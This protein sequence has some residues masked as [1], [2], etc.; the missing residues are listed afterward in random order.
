[1]TQAQGSTN[2]GFHHED[3]DLPSP[4]LPTTI[5][6]VAAAVGALASDTRSQYLVIGERLQALHDRA[7][8]HEKASIRRFESLLAAVVNNTD[9]TLALRSEVTAM[10]THVQHLAAKAEVAELGAQVGRQALE[11]VTTEARQDKA[12]AQTKRLAMVRKGAF[13][14]GI[15]LGTALV[16]EWRAALKLFVSLLGG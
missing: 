14:A 11:S 3:R 4:P 6:D 1:M 16:L 2:G 7:G 9:A 10:G 12:I 13:A 5:D 15:A 8:D